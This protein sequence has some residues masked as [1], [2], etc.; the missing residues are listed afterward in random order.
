MT[1]SWDLFDECRAVL[2][3][4]RHLLEEELWWNLGDAP[5]QAAFCADVSVTSTPLVKVTPWTTL[6]N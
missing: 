5:D 2:V 6:G 4:N 1:K 3:T